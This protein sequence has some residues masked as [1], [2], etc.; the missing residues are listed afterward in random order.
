MQAEIVFW[1]RKVDICR[2]EVADVKTQ[3]EINFL[4]TPTTLIVSNF[5]LRAAGQRGLIA[6]N[7]TLS[8][9]MSIVIR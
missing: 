8:H 2:C 4:Q 6:R 9:E 7:A 1:K 5:S 3:V